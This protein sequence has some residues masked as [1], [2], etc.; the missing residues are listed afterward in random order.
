M[1]S[2]GSL[3][4]S[5]DSTGKTVYKNILYTEIQN[6]KMLSKSSIYFVFKENGMALFFKDYKE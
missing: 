5:K 1:F 4:I 6:L 3:N 2:I